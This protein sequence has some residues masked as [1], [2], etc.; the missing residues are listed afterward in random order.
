MADGSGLLKQDFMTELDITHLRRWIG[1]EQILSDLV[2]EDLARRYHATLDLPGEPPKQ[3]EHVSRLIHFCL[4]Q[5]A[6]PTSTLG[7]DGHPA[8]GS[9]LPPVPLP[10]RMWAGGTLKFQQDLKVGDTIRRISRIE[11]VVLK[12]GRTGALCFVSVSHCIE[13]EGVVHV[14]ERQEIVY[15][16]YS[17][18]GPPKYRSADSNINSNR[19]SI[20]EAAL[21]RYSALTFNSHRIHYDLQY[22]KSIEGYPDL[23]VH[24]PLQATLLLG[25]ATQIR[26]GAPTQFSYRGVYPLFQGEPFSLNARANGEKLEVWT[27]K[28]NGAVCMEGTAAWA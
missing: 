10:R 5:P 11:D 21:F 27:A 1:R 4:A 28:D 25:Y 15:R 6:A 3:G 16:D 22:T 18:P 13:A 12:E 7:G 17:I 19:L 24:A 26:H 2:T 20:N 23:V 9:F 14:K 8:R